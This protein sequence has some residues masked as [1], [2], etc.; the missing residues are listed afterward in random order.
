MVHDGM[1]NVPKA[2]IKDEVA[3]KLKCKADAITVYGLHTKFGG[4]RTSGFALI[5]D[6]LDQKKKYDFK[7]RLIKVSRVNSSR[8]PNV[9]AF[10]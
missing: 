2:Q 10:A 8:I 4:I 3:K 6:S 5:Y 1:A 7:C 9:V